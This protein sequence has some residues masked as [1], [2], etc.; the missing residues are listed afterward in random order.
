MSKSRECSLEDFV[1]NVKPTSPSI[2]G[3]T[4]FLQ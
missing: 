2:E 4:L 1:D 3:G